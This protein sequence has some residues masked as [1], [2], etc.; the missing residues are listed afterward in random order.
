MPPG[1]SGVAVPFT[2][3][4]WI[5]SGV[6]NSFAEVGVP[7]SIAVTGG[8]QF[9]LSIL[10]DASDTNLFDLLGTPV[11]EPSSW[12]CGATVLALLFCTR[13]PRSAL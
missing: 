5:V 7:V 3:G 12:I 4:S 13:D 10:P 2:P 9:W 6:P 11:P 1:S 8:Q